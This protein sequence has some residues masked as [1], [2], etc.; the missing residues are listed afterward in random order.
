MI[1]QHVDSKVALL[2]FS[3]GFFR[4]GRKVEMSQEEV[5]GGR[6]LRDA[7]IRTFEFLY[8]PCPHLELVVHRNGKR[9]RGPEP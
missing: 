8:F 6:L 5:R 9:P 3:R 7:S 4:L 2:L 1:L